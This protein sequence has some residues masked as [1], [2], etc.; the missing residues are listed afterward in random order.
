[1]PVRVWFLAVVGIF[2]GIAG[3]EHDPAEH[4]CP[5]VTDGGLVVTE[6]RG[7]QDPDDALGQWIEIYNAS[8]VD[9]DLAGLVV[10]LRSLDGSRD[11]RILVRTPVTIGTDSYAVIALGDS[12][13]GEYVDYV[14]GT[15]AGAVMPSTGAID[16]D[17]CDDLPTL[18]FADQLLFRNGL[19]STGTYS[20]GLAP[21]TAIGNDMDPNWCT[22]PDPM[23]TPG[24][25]NPACPAPP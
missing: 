8:G 3:C 16:L 10:R 5:D 4:I 18:Q 15:D 24:E 19:P 17:A 11:D 22:N 23:G 12:S 25:A 20:L 14:A 6:L 7:D 21:P 9:L 1:V 13:P 2:G